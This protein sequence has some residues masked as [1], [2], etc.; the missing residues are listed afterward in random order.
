[1][2]TILTILEAPHP[3]LKTRAAPVDAIDGSLLR[4][5]D[6]MLET[7]YAA[8]GIGLAAPQVG[9]TK[10]V[11]VIDT[12][13]DDEPKAPLRLINPQIVWRSPEEIT[14]E[15]GCLSLPD[16]FADVR[17]AQAVRVRYQNERGEMREIDA[18]GLL[19]R[20]LQHE[21]DHLDGILFI[22]HLSPLKRN[23]VLRKL[24]KSRRAK[25]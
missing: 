23:M 4:L 7:M 25:A 14:K 13:K 1:M 20:C 16:Q 19:A 15:E 24:V 17:R 21:V 6:D 10:R 12:A 3:I 11:V 8:P 2:M 5:M 9:V 18:E 22:D